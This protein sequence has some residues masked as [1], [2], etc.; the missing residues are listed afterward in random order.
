VAGI[1][2]EVSSRWQSLDRLLPAA[3]GPEQDGCG[4]ELRV[5]AGDGELLA[6]GSC[7]HWAGDPASLEL[8]WGAATRFELKCLVTG[9]T[10]AAVR[11]GLDRLLP[12]WRD[13]LRTLDSAAGRDSA[14]LIS[15]P[16]R[17][18]GGVEPLLRRGLAPL[19]V[20]AAHV[21]DV[22]APPPEDRAGA[23]PGVAVRQ[24]VPADLGALVEL[25]LEVIRFDA[26][27]GGVNERPSTA[28]ALAGEF[29]EML[30]D[31]QPWIWLAERGDQPVGMLAAEKPRQAAWIAPMT[32]PSPA[33]YVLLAGVAAG[34]RAQGVGAA[35][36]ARLN[37]EA[38]AAGVP[39][40]LLHY[41]QT[42]PLSA[43]F[44]N[45]QGYRPLWTCWEARPAAS[46]R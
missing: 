44:W 34:A 9:Q 41:A 6:E 25:G 42:N 1:R 7:R 14:A 15:W 8:T 30:S 28:S 2:A 35:L 16:S 20:I 43:P 38:R 12:L 10:Q 32:R 27:F 36:A 11:D 19:A 40:T 23:G 13:H 46:L 18:V 33:A 3:A 21:T 22:S 4:A 29:E 17:D 5:L 45:Q 26:H 24:A 31:Q 37:A 39:V